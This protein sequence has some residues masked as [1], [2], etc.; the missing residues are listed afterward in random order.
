VKKQGGGKKTKNNNASGGGQNA[1]KQQPQQPG[2]PNN[3][4]DQLSQQQKGDKPWTKR[5]STI[6]QIASKIRNKRLKARLGFK[7]RTS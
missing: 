1:T 2:K 6:E 4:P 5:E 7:D 3:G